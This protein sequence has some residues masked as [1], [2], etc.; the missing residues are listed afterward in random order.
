MTIAYVVELTINE[1][2]LDAFKK[3]AEGYIASVQAKEPETLT[4]QW[5]IAEDGTRCILHERFTSSEALLAHL[6]NVGP[7]LPELF[8]IAPITRFE[9][10]GSASDEVRAA[11]AD[12]GTVHFPSIGGFDR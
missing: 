2:Q 5:Y 9:V 3:Q 10:L 12:F 6:A 4:Y 8:A 1:G 7:S 11:L